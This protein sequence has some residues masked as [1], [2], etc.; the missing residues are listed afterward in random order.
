M[1]IRKWLPM[2]A[3]FFTMGFA[4]PSPKLVVYIGIDQFPYHILERLNPHFTGGF[5]WLLDHGHL[6]SE[7]YH[8]HAYTVTGTG[9]FTLG[10]GMHPGTGG[11]LGNSWY[12]RIREKRVNCVEDLEAKPLGYPGRKRSYRLVNATALGDWMNPI[13]NRKFFQS[14]G[15]TGR[16]FSLVVKTRTLRCGIIAKANS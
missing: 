5:R 12:D 15:K 9:Y 13:Q 3:I 2:A 1:K 14:E 6:Y 10:S 11:I 4:S 8:D 16:P 7:A